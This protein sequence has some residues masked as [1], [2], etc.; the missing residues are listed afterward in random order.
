MNS[1]LSW[2]VDLLDR[3]KQDGTTHFLPTNL[4]IVHVETSPGAE[5]VIPAWAKA[6]FN[7]RFNDTYTGQTLE[8]KLR[9][10][11]DSCKLPY[12][13]DIHVGG[14]SFYTPPG[15]YSD[16]V[17]K[18]VKKV[19]GRTPE[20]STTGG[21][22]DARFIRNHCPVVECG[23]SNQTAHK[24]DERIPAD[25][26]TALTRIYTEIIADFFTP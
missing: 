20:L 10:T 24:V 7:V 1:Y 18:A 21:T 12:A 19:T 2:E 6:T 25:D 13:M 8:K 11:L 16:M 23:V 22:S 9:D 15:K 3:I 4:E 5:N 26:I 14:E 17:A